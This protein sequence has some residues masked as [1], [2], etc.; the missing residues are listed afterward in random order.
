[1]DNGRKKIFLVDD[2]EYSLLRTKQYLKDY[3]TVYTLDSAFR[4]LELLEKVKPDIIL[5]D[6]NMPG[7]DGYE[8][9]K[10]IKADKRHADIPVIFLSGNDDEDSIVKGLSLG[11]VDH[12]TKPYTPKDLHDR[13]AFHLHPLENQYELRLDTDKNLSKPSIFAVDDSPSMLRSIHFALRNHYKVHT[14][15]KPENLKKVI[16][17]I[18]TDLFLLDYYMPVINGFELVRIIREFPK[19][20]K[21]PII[22]LTSES[23][24]DHLSEA[25]HLG[26]ND[27]IVKPFNPRKLRDKISKALAKK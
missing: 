8:A 14:L 7:L 9:L 21:T 19:F 24:S 15:Q 17:G 18:K 25:V 1:M 23:S 22:F 26:I 13:I 2:V 16:G 12:V 6:I 20:E 11:A 4:M 10:K 27:Y 3:Y 5:L